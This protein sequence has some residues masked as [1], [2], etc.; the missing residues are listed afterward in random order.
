MLSFLATM[1]AVAAGATTLPASD[2]TNTT[3]TLNGSVEGATTA[4]FVY[5]TT[6]QYGIP[7][8][9]QAVT[10]GAVSAPIEDLSADTT[11]H[12]KIVSD[13]G[14]GDDVT[15]R[16]APNPKPPSIGDQHAAAITAGTAHVSAT[17]NP[18]GA[19]TTYY[20]QYGRTTGYGR[21]SERITVPAGTSPVAVAADLS[22]L[23]PYARYHWRLYATNSA[24]KTPGRDHT[25]R[26]ARVATALTLFS[27]QGTVPW[28]RGVMLGGRVTGAG[29]H[30]MTLALEQQAFPF[31]A[32][33]A[34]VRTTQAGTDGGYLF[35]VDNVWT[36]TRFH[37]V[38]Q[39]Q[40]PLTSAPATV[41][42]TP[43]T[44]IA[45]R[46]LSRKRA[47]ISGTISPAITGE[48]SLQRRLASGHWAQIKRRALTGAKAFSFKVWRARRVDR[49]YRVVVLPV[50][51]AYVKAKSRSVVVSRRPA[52]ARGHRAAA[53]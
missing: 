24:G 50:K 19:A 6:T 31:D 22:A 43:R 38:S 30:G 39:T 33:F 46:T 53:G 13:A 4:H 40:T 26:T 15:F 2:V 51:G 11:Y 52:R 20:F 28:G 21:R 29:V 14:E 27:D 1:L 12:F 32:G 10:D 18:N 17:L 48:L 37:V 45:A 5:G 9:N 36:L 8:P 49:A 41:R 35:S 23:A 16:T 47:R 3:A 44:H 7:T 42:S 34:Q 25:F